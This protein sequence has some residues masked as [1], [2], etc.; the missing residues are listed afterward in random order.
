VAVTVRLQV[1]ICDETLALNAI[2]NYASVTSSSLY[3]VSPNERSQKSVIANVLS[4]F[5]PWCRIQREIKSSPSSYLE[6]SRCCERA[7][8]A[9]PY[10]T[11]M[12]KA[13]ATAIMTLRLCRD[14]N[15]DFMEAGG[16]GERAAV[17]FPFLDFAF[18]V[19]GADDEGVIVGAIGSPVV[20][21]ERPG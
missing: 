7:C 9:L 5:S 16:T 19:G 6:R 11:Q 17:F 10:L 3:P 15:D 2:V 8:S 1:V 18:A 21:P 13:E 12:Q 14:M 20:A 4:L